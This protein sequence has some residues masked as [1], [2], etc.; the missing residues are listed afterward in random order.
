MSIDRSLIADMDPFVGLSGHELDVILQDTHSF[1]VAKED[2]IFEQ[3][4]D[5]S[6]FFLLLDG[7]VRVVQTSKGGTRL[8]RRRRPTR[9]PAVWAQSP[10]DQLTVWLGDRQYRQRWLEADKTQARAA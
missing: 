5:A 9:L 7:I 4:D 1:R 2:A 6:R 10:A 3:G 8:F